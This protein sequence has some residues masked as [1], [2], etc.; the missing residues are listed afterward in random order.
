MLHVNILERLRCKYCQ[1]GFLMA[2][3]DVLI[4]PVLLILDP[5]PKQEV[6]NDC[7]RNHCEEFPETRELYH[8][9][10][11]AMTTLNLKRQLLAG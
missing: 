10:L 5:V 3:Q 11:R 2:N 6:C 1:K 8:S 9:H 7:F 4:P